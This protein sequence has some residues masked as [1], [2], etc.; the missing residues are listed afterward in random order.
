[1]TSIDRKVAHTRRQ[2]GPAE[3]TRVILWFVMRSRSTAFTRAIS[4]INSIEIIFEPYYAAYAYGPERELAGISDLVPEETEITYRWVKRLLER[5]RQS[6]APVFVKDCT[7]AL[8][9]GR[10]NELPDGY[11]HAF[12]I[13][14]PLEICISLAR[15]LRNHHDKAR[16][17][18]MNDLD[19]LVGYRRMYDLYSF[20][21]DTRSQP[22]LV[23]QSSNLSRHPEA[24]LRRFCHHVGLPYT[25]RMLSWSKADGF[26]SNWWVS[27]SDQLLNRYTDTYS[28]ALGS[29]AFQARSPGD[30]PQFADLPD[31]YKRAIDHMRPYYQFLSERSATVGTFWV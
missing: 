14:E 7:S 19:D 12:L 3:Q 29:R 25:Q 4:Q 22:P 20:V 5:R 9:R 24:V 8:P 13:R 18:A 1:M 16:V 28:N 6:E 21:A 17:F 26:P 23:I 11:Q 30:F 27:E 2:D 15:Y 10:Y 31:S